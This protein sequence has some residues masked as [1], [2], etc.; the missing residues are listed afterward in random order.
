MLI[1]PFGIIVDYHRKP[2]TSE[3]QIYSFCQFCESFIVTVVK[4]AINYLKSAVLKYS[5]ELN[6]H[7]GVSFLWIY[8]FKTYFFLNSP[9]S[10]Q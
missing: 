7:V 10:F 5:V 4:P 6:W 3:K 2:K 9:R 8:M 1:E